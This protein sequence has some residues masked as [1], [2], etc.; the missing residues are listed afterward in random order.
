MLGIFA[1]VFKRATHQ[2]DRFL[3]APGDWRPPTYWQRKPGQSGLPSPK[4]PYND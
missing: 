2:D 1:D 3:D 4:G